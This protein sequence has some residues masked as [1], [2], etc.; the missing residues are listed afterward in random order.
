[1]ICLTEVDDFIKQNNSFDYSKHYAGDCQAG[2]ENWVGS[3]AVEEPNAA[4]R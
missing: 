3:D 4:A 2:I 1:M